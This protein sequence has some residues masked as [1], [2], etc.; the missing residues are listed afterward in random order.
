[1]DA[2][3]VSSLTSPIGHIVNTV[4]SYI[5][6]TRR[7]GILHN[8]NR[9]RVGDPFPRGRPALHSSETFASK[10]FAAQDQAGI[11]PATPLL[12]YWTPAGS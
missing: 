5:K 11:V 4:V 8:C 9:L 10:L 12:Y 3:R 7:G 2:C 1:M 6:V